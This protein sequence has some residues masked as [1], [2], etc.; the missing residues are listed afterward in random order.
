VNSKEV[1][2]SVADQPRHHLGD[3]AYETI[4]KPA[5]LVPNVPSNRGFAS[6]PKPLPLGMISGK[7]NCTLTVKIARVYL[8]PVAREEITARGALWGTDIYTDDSDMVAACIHGGWIRG[9][10]ADDVEV[11]MLDLDHGIT[12]GAEREPINGRRRKD[13]EREERAK[14]EANAAVELLK[15][16]KTGPVDVPTDRDLHVTVVILPRLEKYYS[17][18]RF[19]IRSREFGG[20]HAGRRSTHDGISF[21]ITGIRW[22]ENGAGAQSRLRGKARRERIRKAF[23]EIQTAATSA[24]GEELER[25]MEKLRVARAKI[26]AGNRPSKNEG[27][28][29]DVK[30]DVEMMDAVERPPSEGDKEN[31]PREVANA[32]SSPV[33]NG[34]SESGDGLVGGPRAVEAGSGA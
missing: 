22:V 17:T 33:R 5:R 34:G 12:N 8:T 19:G 30:G 1:F 15:A 9:E 20:T 10:W 18:T 11:G 31:R 23:M 32:S 21:A 26:M 14:L 6:T 4:L 13:K 16:P 28:Q 24:T 3:V 2:D 29:D 27:G 25:K 7:E